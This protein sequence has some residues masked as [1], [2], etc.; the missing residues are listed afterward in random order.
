MGKRNTLFIQLINLQQEG[1]ITKHIQ[2]FQKLSLRVKNIPEDNLLDL[3]KGILKEGIQHEV[4]ICE[5]KSLEKDFIILRKVENKNMATRRVVT[6]NY[7]EHHVPSPNLTQPKRLIPQQ[8]DEI[9]EK[10][11]CFNCENK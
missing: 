1:Q 3:F 7:R 8:M 2:Q 6:S 11:L 4:H 10:G 5:P 9:R